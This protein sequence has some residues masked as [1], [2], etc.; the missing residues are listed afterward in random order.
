MLIGPCCRYRASV[1][2]DEVRR[3]E[4]HEALRGYDPR[5]VDALLDQVAVALD[6]GRPVAALV[7]APALRRRLRGYRT[8]DVDGLLERLRLEHTDG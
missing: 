4:F 8:T 2:G 1:T 5:Q 7:A 6:A 3:C